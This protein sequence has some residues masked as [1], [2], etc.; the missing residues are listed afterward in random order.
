MVFGYYAFFLCFIYEPDEEKTNQII[1]WLERDKRVQN[2]TEE[3]KPTLFIYVV[4]AKD[5]EAAG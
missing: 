1:G 5:F 4:I 3:T 2:S